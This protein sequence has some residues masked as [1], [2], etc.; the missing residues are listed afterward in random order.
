MWMMDMEIRN[1][2]LLQLLVIKFQWKETANNVTAT[3]SNSTI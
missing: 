3:T 2:Q 1:M